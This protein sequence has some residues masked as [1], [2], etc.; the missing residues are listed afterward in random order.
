MHETPISEDQ[1][2]TEKESD[3]WH[4][5]A[6]VPHTMQLLGWILSYGAMIN[7]LGPEE[8]GEFV[9]EQVLVAGGYYK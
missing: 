9:A 4:L 5:K 3:I 2:L 8:V 7:V 1:E 6:T